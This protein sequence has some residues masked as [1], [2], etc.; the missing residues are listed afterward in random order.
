[1]QNVVTA[2]LSYFFYSKFTAENFDAFSQ[3]YCLHFLKIQI[4]SRN[5][6]NWWIYWNFLHLQ[7]FYRT[8][9]MPVL[10]AF[11]ARIYR[12]IVQGGKYPGALRT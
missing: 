7:K 10:I 5:V 9:K 1:M 6:W 11:F 3:N 4:V 2:H 8:L 12:Q